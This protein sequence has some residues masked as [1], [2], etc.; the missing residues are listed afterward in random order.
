M[1]VFTNLIQLL[2]FGERSG[3][4]TDEPEGSRFIQISDTLAL[5]IAA[6]LEE[7]IA[8]LEVK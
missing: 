4:A 3:A 1:E 6:A 2:R 5:Q 7:E 8:K